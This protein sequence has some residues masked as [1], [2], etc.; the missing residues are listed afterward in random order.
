MVRRLPFSHKDLEYREP[1]F[2]ILEFAR[3]N[4]VIHKNI[5]D[6]PFLFLKSYKIRRF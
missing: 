3:T 2:L 5:V 6:S 1:E 4:G